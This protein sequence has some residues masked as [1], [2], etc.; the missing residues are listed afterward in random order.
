[1]NWDRIEGTW[2]RLKGKARARWG[3]LNNDNVDVIA[4]KREQVVGNAQ[5][6]YGI[7]KEKVGKQVDRLASS[8]EKRNLKP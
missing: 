2:K 7:G 8:L 5:E 4:G 3:K 6:Q 1:M